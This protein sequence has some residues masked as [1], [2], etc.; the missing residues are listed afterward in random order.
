MAAKHLIS[1]ALTLEGKDWI[2][3]FSNIQWDEGGR[4][5]VE[6][7]WIKNFISSMDYYSRGAVEHGSNNTISQ[8]QI[9]EWVDQMNRQRVKQVIGQGR[10]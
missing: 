10:G 1:Q 5:K 4:G 2:A 6:S 8:S 3:N 9:S 7:G